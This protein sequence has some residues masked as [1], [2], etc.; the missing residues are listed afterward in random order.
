MIVLLMKLRGVLNIGV[1][2]AVVWAAIFGTLGIVIG[3]VR[4]EVIDPGEEPVRIATIL[5]GVG[6]LAGILFGLLLSF[7]ESA[8][9]IRDIALSR[10]AVWGIIASAAFPLLTDRADQ[11][12]ILC[13]IGAIL[14]IAGIA[15]ARKA[16]LQNTPQRRNLL[17][18]YVLQSVRDAVNPR[19]AASSL[20]S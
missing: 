1:A 20:S 3:I 9:P 8:R 18:A 14:A 19:T 12:F 5:G 4:P 11:V 13:P 16:E 6:L 17:A 7:A 10:A 15:I 2:W